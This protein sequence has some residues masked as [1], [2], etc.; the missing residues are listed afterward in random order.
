MVLNKQHGFSLL[1]VLI[2]FSILAFSLTILMQI[3]ST[4]INSAVLAE[5]Y[6]TAV[7]IAESLMAKTGLETRPQTSHS[8]GEEDKKYRWDVSVRPFNFVVGKFEKQSTAE[9]Y[10]IDVSVNWGEQ[11][12]NEREVHLTTLKLANK[13]QQ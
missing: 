7:Q 9:L 4:G 12:D 11:G 1:E 3:F 2:A 5:E 13:A 10:K 8:A 6:T